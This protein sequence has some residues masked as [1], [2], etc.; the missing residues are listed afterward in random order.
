MF[1][2]S[3]TLILV[4]LFFQASL[5][6]VDSKNLERARDRIAKN[7]VNFEGE[8]LTKF[9]W[10]SDNDLAFETVDPDGSV[11]RQRYD[12]AQNLISPLA[13]DIELSDP[14]MGPP[15][16]QANYQVPAPDARL[17]PDGRYVV[18]RRGPNLVLI[19]QR[20]GTHS[21]VTM[22]GAVDFVY[23]GG[24]LLEWAGQVAVQEAD[25]PWPASVLWS[26]DSRYFVTPIADVRNVR[27]KTYTTAKKV[28]EGGADFAIYN[29]RHAMAGDAHLTEA[30]FALIDVQSKAVTVLEMPTPYQKSGDPIRNNRVSWSADSKSVYFTYGDLI[31]RNAYVFR[32][33]L[34]DG[35]VVTEWSD[36]GY[37]L[38]HW[39]DFWPLPLIGGE[40]QFI[41]PSEKD[42]FR[43]LYSVSPGREGGIETK[44]TDGSLYVINVYGVKDDW[45]YFNAAN[46]DNKDDPYIYGLY[47]AKIDGGD[48][49]LISPVGV[50]VTAHPSEDLQYFVLEQEFLD[51]PNAHVVIDA[52]GKVLQ[53]LAQP[54]LKEG[55][56]VIERV[57]GVT[58]DKQNPIW[59]SIHKPTDFDPSK[60]YPVIHHVHGTVGFLWGSVGH[61][62]GYEISQ[63]QALADLG[64]IV[65][66]ADGL[67][68]IGRTQKYLKR[69]AITGH[70]CGGTVDSVMLLKQLAKDRPYMDLSRVGVY[71]YSQGGNCA[72]RAIFE[73]PDDIHVAVAGA[74]NHDSRFIH[75]A[76]IYGYIGGGPEDF[77]QEYE[78]QNNASLA[79]QLEGKILFVNGA[80]DDDVPLAA[81][82][83]V[84]NVLMKNN[85]DY[86]LTILPNYWHNAWDSS[87]Y[88]HKVWGY[89]TEHL[90]EKELGIFEN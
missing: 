16:T 83:Q 22:D 33:S 80:I 21:P 52:T 6:Q 57:S 54:S 90:S 66:A 2:V 53:V 64:F 30:K 14:E 8:K 65:L 68:S 81:T 11:K 47:R 87:Y 71:G 76:E 25:E 63:R 12:A 82:Y 35:E 79:H 37:F 28:P 17:S 38:G 62:D 89:F 55:E 43:H 42:G 20:N 48:Q 56:P 15:G 18:R 61:R 36:N 49:Q 27:T 39:R 4:C 46:V 67:G 74:G 70:Q 31:E 10:L 44:I 59:A 73:F 78:A 69:A 58:R 19:D 9:K 13:G 50:H 84:I 51:R 77:P 75:P 60:S 72:S 32:Y 3:F 1:F 40:R 41:V 34:D 26:P 86:D 45:V 29:V 88:W 85:K 7:Y 24:V 5:A 23:G